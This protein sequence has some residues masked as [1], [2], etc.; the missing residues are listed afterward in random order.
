MM[1]LWF[2]GDQGTGKSSVVKLFSFFSSLERSTYRFSTSFWG[3][4]TENS[5]K[6]DLAPFGLD[7]YLTKDT[8]LYYKG[9]AYDFQVKDGITEFK[10]KS[11]QIRKKYQVPKLVYI[12]AERNLL[13]IINSPEKL[14]YLPKYLFTFI[15]EFERS[16]KKLSGDLD[17]PLTGDI[18]F[19]YQKENKTAYI[20]GIDY[21]IKLSEASSGLQSLLPLYLVSRNLAYSI[22]KKR[23]N[24]ETELTGEAQQKI[25]AE[26]ERILVDNTLSKEVKEAALQVLSS[27][28]T[29]TCFINVVEEIEQNLF[30]SSQK[31]LLFKLLEFANL[32][33]SNQLILT[34]HSPYIINY[35]TLAIKGNAVLKNIN[36]TNNSKALK[37]R[38][39]KIIPLSSC[40]ASE[41]TIVYTLMNNGTIKR[42]PTYEGM[43][44]D[45]NYLNES[46]SDTN[47]AFDELLNIEE[48]ANPELKQFA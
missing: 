1:A 36:S 27:K 40:V 31:E 37:E 38:L 39:E 34:T 24:S 12:P 47:K 35:L 16:K 3:V 42:L 28:F 33:D 11:K 7:G 18:K 48:D 15:E 10:L 6:K 20:K 43:P 44:S 32:I 17:I 29:D 22:N 14:K 25:K 8:E 13:S 46:L 23:N 4:R 30:P 2:I 45:D 41:D 26:V 5:I 9:N 19:E 21:K